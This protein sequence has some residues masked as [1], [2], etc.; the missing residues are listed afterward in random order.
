MVDSTADTTD[1][2]G[3][4]TAGM[5]SVGATGARALS[6]ATAIAT[7]RNPKDSMKSTWRLG[8]RENWNYWQRTIDDRVIYYA[9][10]DKK[11]P[12]HQKSE[13]VPHVP[14]WQCHVWVLYHAAIPMGLHQAFVSLTGWD[15]HPVAVWG[16]YTA[17]IAVFGIHHFR[18]MRRMGHLY[19]FLDGDKHGRDEIPDRSARKAMLSVIMTI[20]ARMAMTIL[21]TYDRSVPPMQMDWLALPA[22]VFLYG[23]VLDFWFYWYH[24]AMHESET[25]WKYHRTHH[26]TKHPTP[27][28]TLFADEEQEVFDIIGV[29]LFTFFSMKLMGLPMGYYEWWICHTYVI[30]TELIGHSGLRLHL[31]TIT[32]NW[33]LKYFDCELLIEDHDL[34]HRIGYKKSHNYGKQTRLWDRIFGTLGD[35]IEDVGNNVDYENPAYWPLDFKGRARHR[36]KRHQAIPD[37]GR[38]TRER[39]NHRPAEGVSAISIVI[40]PW[41]IERLSDIR[42]PWSDQ[43]C[44]PCPIPGRPVVKLDTACQRAQASLLRRILVLERPLAHEEVAHGNDAHS[45]GHGSHGPALGRRDLPAEAPV[46][47]VADDAG[48]RSREDAVADEDGVVAVVLHL[49]EQRFCFAFCLSGGLL[50]GH[51]GVVSLAV[52]ALS[53]RVCLDGLRLEAAVNGV[54]VGR[55]YVDEGV[56]VGNGL[57]LDFRHDGR[58]ARGMVQYWDRRGA[59]GG[60]DDKRA[61]D[62]GRY[63]GARG[64][65]EQCAVR[66][67]QRAEAAQHMIDLVAGLPWHATKLRRHGAR[68]LLVT[69]PAT[70][71]DW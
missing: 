37:W 39:E 28:L 55:V 7:S 67:V 68:R 53:L 64:D 50:R 2:S 33:F 3:S 58:P 69:A 5:T 47:T 20:T 43:C 29:P 4:S 10:L 19:G 62:K 61:I 54:D 70:R 40:K 38:A 66:W 52:Q 65:I 13:K 57:V 32:S 25:L 41:S 49:F 1:I 45:R 18:V 16:L 44:L 51:L 71:T 27:L 34:H 14:Q 60:G 48:E 31:G 42:L 9:D 22:E 59:S 11:I 36:Q 17:A 46:C 63:M 26:L 24:R 6:T 15:L 30:W 56:V 35:R 12:V 23:I 8:N 21:L